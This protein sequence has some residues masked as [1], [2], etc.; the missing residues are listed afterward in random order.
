MVMNFYLMP[1]RILTFV[2]GLLVTYLKVV[3]ISETSSDDAWL[4]QTCFFIPVHQFRVA[5]RTC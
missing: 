1:T 4:A 5:L 3:I 2:S